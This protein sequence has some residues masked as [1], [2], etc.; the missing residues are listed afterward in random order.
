[1]KIKIEGSGTFN[2]R[3]ESTTY[4]TDADYRRLAKEQVK[5]PEAISDDIKVIADNAYFRG[6]RIAEIEEQ[7]RELKREQAYDLDV[8]LPAALDALG[9][10]DLEVLLD[11]KSK[12]RT[13]IRTEYYGSIP[14]DYDEA[15]MFIESTP[16]YESKTQIVTQLK[17]HPMTL[18]K[19]VREQF[20]GGNIR[21]AESVLGASQVRRAKVQ[22]KEAKRI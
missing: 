5:I 6:E 14:S 7:L 15:R 10:E 17:I 19:F 9:V 20:E 18:K 4:Y 22:M 12:I 2:R 13:S 11:D 1:M 8:V 16:G 3:V 21:A